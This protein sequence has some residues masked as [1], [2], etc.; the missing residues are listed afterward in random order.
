MCRFLSFN[1][2]QVKLFLKLAE[3]LSFTKAAKICGVTQSAMSR[4]I[5]SLED[6]LG[7]LLFIRSTNKVTLTPAGV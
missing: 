5:K 2:F 4:N 7:I 6:A 1:L 3:T